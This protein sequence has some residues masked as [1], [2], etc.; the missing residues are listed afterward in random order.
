MPL[1]YL[2]RTYPYGY[3]KLRF[4]T[5][6]LHLVPFLGYWE[7]SLFHISQYPPLFFRWDGPVGKIVWGT[8]KSHFSVLRRDFPVGKPLLGVLGNQTF[9]HFDPNGSR[10]E[11]V[12][13]GQFVI[14]TWGG[15]ETKESHFYI[16]VL[17]L[18]PKYLE[19]L[20]VYRLS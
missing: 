2:D 10:W 14:P 16:D 6:Y 20:Q 15:M 5:R 4:A 13:T 11:I 12:C 8:G 7:I 1:A 18:K 19:N 9:F 3:Q 17:T